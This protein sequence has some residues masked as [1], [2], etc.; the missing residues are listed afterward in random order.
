MEVRFDSNSIT[1]GTEFMV[2]LQEQLQAF[3]HRKMTLDPLWR[4]ISV[5]FSGHEVRALEMRDG[6]VEEEIEP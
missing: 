4:G 3:L 1:P 2:K 5:I 6:D